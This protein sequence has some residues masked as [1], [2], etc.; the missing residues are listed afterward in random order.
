MPRTI[1][2]HTI[3]CNSFIFYQLVQD[4][5]TIHLTFD[6]CRHKKATIA[7]QEKSLQII[8]LPDEQVQI[9]T[10]KDLLAQSSPF[11]KL[12][13]SLFIKQGTL[14][15]Q[16]V[17][18]LISQIPYGSTRT[19]GYL[20]E[21]MGNKKQARA[22]GQACNANPL[23]LFIPC[24]RVV[25]VSGLGG[26]AGGVEIKEKLLRLELESKNKKTNGLY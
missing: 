18:K 12:T 13:E 5:Q 10:L 21:K 24:H 16:K 20:A 11:S 8:N 25:G 6:Q 3:T 15:Q 19:Y 7:L 26:F 4:E 9:N 1:S 17:W 23:A 14:F 22:V 2:S